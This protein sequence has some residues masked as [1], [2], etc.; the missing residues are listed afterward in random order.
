MKKTTLPTQ[1]IASVLLPLAAFWG[2]GL[3]ACSLSPSSDLDGSVDL[4]TA[5]PGFT[6]YPIGRPGQSCGM[7]VLD[8][9]AVSQQKTIPEYSI[10]ECEQYT[11]TA[12]HVCNTSRIDGTDYHTGFH[13]YW[14]MQGKVDTFGLPTSTPYLKAG[15]VVQE[16]E[17]VWLSYDPSEQSINKIDWNCLTDNNGAFSSDASVELPSLDAMLGG[18][19]FLMA[20]MSTPAGQGAI[21]A[22]LSSGLCIAGVAI[23]AVVTIGAINYFR[24]EPRVG[25]SSALTYTVPGVEGAIV[26]GPDGLV[27]GGTGGALDGLELPDDPEAA[28]E[29]IARAI[30]KIAKEQGAEVAAQ[31]LRALLQKL[32]QEAL[33]LN[34]EALESGMGPDG[35]SS[36]LLALQQ[37]MS[38]IARALSS[39]LIELP[40]EA[41]CAIAA[42]LLE[43]NDLFLIELENMLMR[44]VAQ[45][46][47]GI[48]STRLSIAQLIDALLTAMNWE[49]PLG[50]DKNFDEFMGALETHNSS[51]AGN[52]FPWQYYGMTLVNLQG[53]AQLMKLNTDCT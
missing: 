52:L 19:V 16:F 23:V 41:K 6:A 27:V 53:A 7:E 8:R 3:T 40:N 11:G 38:N 30:E 48:D 42:V 20:T 5:L 36:A 9:L 2:P 4:S 32:L 10:D 49:V 44:F 33:R 46:Q 18:S 26:D 39:S 43:L 24:I 13:T 22:C 25:G 34:K 47:F 35:Q 45:D 12:F 17:K 15:L 21:L 50:Y 14:A 1:V 28:A 51:Y 37:L 31:A 29:A